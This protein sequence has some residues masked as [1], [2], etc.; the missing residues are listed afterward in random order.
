MRVTTVKHLLLAL[1]LSSTLSHGQSAASGK[2][3]LPIPR[4]IEIP[5]LPTVPKVLE[6]TSTKVVAA[7]EF[8]GY[9]TSVCDDDG[10]V[11]YHV[12]S[13]YNESTVFRLSTDEEKHG[14]FKLPREIADAAVF[15]AFNVTPSGK[16]WIS[17][18]NQKG[19]NVAY[20]FDSDGEVTSRVSFDTP[21]YLQPDLFAAFETD[22][23]LLHGFYAKQADPQL[24]GSTYMAILGPSGKLIRHLNLHEP[25]VNFELQRKSIP[26]GAVA[27]GSDGNAYMLLPDQV[28]VVSQSGRIVRKLPLAKPDRELRAVNIYVSGGLVAVVFFKT[29]EHAIDTRLLVLDAD[30]GD[31]FGYYEASAELGNNPICFSRAQGLTFMRRDKDGKVRFQ[32]A[33]LR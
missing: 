30:T 31:T 6:A 12:G 8:G 21:S 5:P 23:F 11:Y 16:V 7:P 3:T 10:N 4:R 17:V 24:A 20:G 28:V 32:T 33:M 13:S 14:I 1:A 19:E 9:G 25:A 22:V 2:A 26:E 29:R 18:Y 27:V 15:G